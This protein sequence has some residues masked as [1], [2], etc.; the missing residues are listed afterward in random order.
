MRMN[1]EELLDKMPW[2]SNYKLDIVRINYGDEPLHR[3]NEGAY[4]LYTKLECCH[5]ENYMWLINGD[6]DVYETLI[7]KV[8]IGKNGEV[9]SGDIIVKHRGMNYN[10]YLNQM[11]GNNS[12]DIHRNSNGKILGFANKDGMGSPARSYNTNEMDE[13]MIQ[14]IISKQLE[15]YGIGI[16]K[17]MGAVRELY[18]KDKTNHIMSKCFNA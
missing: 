11:Y 15:D 9:L 13:D 18:N 17:F 2:Q 7:G 14:N 10:I 1:K 4:E 8:Y 5:V 12:L 6:F 16:Q 3:W